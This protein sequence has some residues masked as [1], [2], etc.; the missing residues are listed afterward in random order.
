[1]SGDSPLPWVIGSPQAV[2]SGLGKIG[3]SKTKPVALPVGFPDLPECMGLADPV[4]L[5]SP[6]GQLYAQERAAALAA[7]NDDLM[8]EAIL[9]RMLCL[10]RDGLLRAD[11]REHGLNSALAADRSGEVAV[12]MK[13]GGMGPRMWE[14]QV[15]ADAAESGFPGIGWRLALSAW[16]ADLTAGLRL[17]ELFD[18]IG[19]SRWAGFNLVNASVEQWELVLDRQDW[20]P[21]KIVGGYQRPWS[22]GLTAHVLR[23]RLDRLDLSYEMGLASGGE[24]IDWRGNH[25]ARV[26]RWRLV[27]NRDDELA[28]VAQMSVDEGRLPMAWLV[29]GLM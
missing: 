19:A 8:R 14:P 1:M 27:G 18:P 22:M 3:E 26:G 4:K 15:L 7:I 24:E 25:V 16:S 17:R 11:W 29:P 2:L 5:A 12:W 10:A 13:I 6:G 28:R 21:D 23:Q 20:W 9:E